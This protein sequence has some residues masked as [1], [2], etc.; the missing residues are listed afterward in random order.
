MEHSPTIR[1]QL[2]REDWWRTLSGWPAK[3]DQHL[4]R[5]TALTQTEFW[6]E[7][8]TRHNDGGILKVEPAIGGYLNDLSHCH[9]ALNEGL[10]DLF[11][12]KAER[13]VHEY[14]CGSSR[15]G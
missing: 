8:L 10:N 14:Q 1:T 11:N 4:A 9:G 13:A 7:S 5:L 3:V 2:P 12:S 15:G 6:I